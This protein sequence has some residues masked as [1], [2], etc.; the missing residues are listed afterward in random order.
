MYVQI[1]EKNLCLKVYSNTIQYIGLGAE[2]CLAPFPCFMLKWSHHL[3]ARRGFRTIPKNQEYSEQYR[4]PYRLLLIYT[5]QEVI[6]LKRREQ[7]RKIL[8]QQINNKYIKFLC[9]SDVFYAT[10]AI[11]SA[12]W[13]SNF[14]NSAIARPGFKPLGQ[15]FVQFMIVWHLYTEWGSLIL[16]SLSAW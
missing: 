9:V 2:Y 7:K 5:T 6:S 8:Y 11:F 16:L 3:A 10:A 14:F 1:T 4:L 13:V 12:F 15:V